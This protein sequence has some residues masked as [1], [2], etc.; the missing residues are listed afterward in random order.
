MP[1]SIVFAYE[2]GNN[3]FE[4]LLRVS[5]DEVLFGEKVLEHSRVVCRAG[6]RHPTSAGD[7]IAQVPVPVSRFESVPP[8]IV[9]SVDFIANAADVA[10]SQ[11]GRRPDS[12]N[13]W[14][15]CLCAIQA[16]ESTFERVG[17]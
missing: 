1:A 8:T 2:N 17:V 13:N 16:Q 4:D 14:L 6:L 15:Q 7:E 11:K 10:H 9:A 12:L 5:W 3:I